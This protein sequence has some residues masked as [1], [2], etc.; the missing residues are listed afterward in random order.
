MIRYILKAVD[1]NA[2]LHHFLLLIAAD[3]LLR[4]PLAAL[5]AA[6]QVQF[7]FAREQWHGAH[8]AQVHPYR[9]VGVNRLF[10]R[11]LRV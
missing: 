8:L 9:V 5:H 1:L 10:Y 4:P 6:R 3:G 7:S 11:R 2:V